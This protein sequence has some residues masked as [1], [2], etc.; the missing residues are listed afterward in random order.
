MTD[1]EPVLG[2]WAIAAERVTR[3]TFRIEVGAK[4]GTAFLIS[5]AAGEAPSRQ[6]LMLAT[7]WHV[8]LEAEQH[9]CRI[10]LQSA[11][12]TVS[13][14]N[15]DHEIHI[16]RLGPPQLDTALVV[17]RSTVEAFSPQ[18]LIP[19]LPHDYTPARGADVGW[20]GFPSLVWPQLCFFKGVISGYLPD[21]EVFFVDGVAINGVS[22]G[23]AFNHE[24]TLFGLVSSYIPNR[25]NQH[26]T[27]PGLMTLVPV[28]MIDYWMQNVLRARGIPAG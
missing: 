2:P 28:R 18:E 16:F 20:L 5:I 8:V 12:G 14:S 4:A 15:S 11:N 19:L 6:H 21:P 27:L 22:G 1:V 25:L 23:P 3:I 17:A 9:K 13:L 10:A 24:P 26:T 7:A